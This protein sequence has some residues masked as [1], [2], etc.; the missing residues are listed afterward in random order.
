MAPV[1]CKMRCESV[2]VRAG[3]K[4]T[5]VTA[6]LKGATADI[7]DGWD[8]ASSKRKIQSVAVN[9]EFCE[10]WPASRVKR[11]LGNS[12]TVE[13]RLRSEISTEL[14]AAHPAA[15]KEKA[16]AIQCTIAAT[17][18]MFGNWLKASLDNGDVVDGAMDCG[19]PVVIAY[20]PREVE[21]PTTADGGQAKGLSKKREK[22]PEPRT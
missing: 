17:L 19:V 20:A 6:L 10:T 3:S 21:L 22:A 5:V 16:A 18:E 12:G 15:R 13:I 1:K 14:T 4:A 8:T 9:G 7:P 2:S 11:V